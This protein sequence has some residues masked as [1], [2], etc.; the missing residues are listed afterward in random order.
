MK[1][2]NKLSIQGCFQWN[3]G[4]ITWKVF[5]N[6]KKSSGNVTNISWY[7]LF[8]FL[9]PKDLQSSYLPLSSNAFRLHPLTPQWHTTHSP[10]LLR[11]P[12]PWH[13]TLGGF[14]YTRLPVFCFA[15]RW[16][17]SRGREVG[18]AESGFI[19]S[20][21]GSR[22]WNPKG[23]R[24]RDRRCLIRVC[25]KDTTTGKISFPFLLSQELLF[26]ALSI[27]SSRAFSSII[28]LLVK[29]LYSASEYDYSLFWWTFNIPRRTVPA[30]LSQI[31]CLSPSLLKAHQ[32]YSLLLLVSLSPT[33]F[34]Q[35]IN[36]QCFY[37][38]FPYL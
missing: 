22:Q 27:H 21:L 26:C 29:I 4:V 35:L 15:G 6:C 2:V 32:P 28:R 33:H 5:L 31:S 30:P 24:D 20:Y 11:L 8:N 25:I 1:A 23:R 14:N 7:H 38:I 36:S 34:F 17:E 16:Q 10:L 19:S 12:L 3:R 9:L 18:R 13:C 37:L